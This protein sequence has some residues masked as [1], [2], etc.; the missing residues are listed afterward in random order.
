MK[1][2]IVL[3]LLL[4]CVPYHILFISSIVIPYTT[5]NKIISSTYSEGSS[6][7]NGDAFSSAFAKNKYTSPLGIAM[8]NAEI[9]PDISNNSP[10]QYPSKIETADELPTVSEYYNGESNLN[11]IKLNCTIYNQ[12]TCYTISSCGWCG[13]LNKCISGNEQT[14]YEPLCI[15]STYIYSLQSHILNSNI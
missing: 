3:T 5:N 9:S 1:L 11:V 14:P 13:N 10:F 15:R 12:H 7:Q 4:L 6:F 2:L 8:K